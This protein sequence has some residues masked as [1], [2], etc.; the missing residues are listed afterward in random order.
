MLRDFQNEAVA[1]VLGFERVQDRRQ[2]A[3][4]RHVDN[5]ADN[6]GNLA[7]AV[8]RCGFLGGSCLSHYPYPLSLPQSASAPEMISMSS[9]VI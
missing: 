7:R 2:F 5:S 6:L 4:E 3:F 1:V 9:L 8:H